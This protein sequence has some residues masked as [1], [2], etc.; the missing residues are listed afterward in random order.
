[1]LTE[2]P[3]DTSVHAAPPLRDTAATVVASVRPPKGGATAASSSA[4][5][6][7]APSE[8]V[9]VAVDVSDG[10]AEAV[11]VADKTAVAVASAVLDPEGVAVGES[12]GYA[13]EVALGEPMEESV[14][15][16]EE[17]A[18]D[19]PMADSVGWEVAVSEPV[20]E[21]VGWD[22]TVGGAEKVAVAEGEPVE[23]A[24]GEGKEDDVALVVALSVHTGPVNIPYT[25]TVEPTSRR[26][27]NTPGPPGS[28]SAGAKLQEWAMGGGSRD[29]TAPPHEKNAMIAVIII[30]GKASPRKKQDKASLLRILGSFQAAAPVRRVPPPW[31]DS[32]LISWRS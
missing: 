16:A 1:M 3:P 2:P 20:E 29:P 8:P 24:E 18:V 31:R 30:I 6:R 7:S 11:G 14:G 19:E 9:G 23:D 12:V 10:S 32:W 4:R 22:D 25:S 27:R 5:R 17:V 15:Y 21:S 13:D 28:R 26:R